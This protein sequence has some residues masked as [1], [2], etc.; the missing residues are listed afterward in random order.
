M[1]KIIVLILS[2]FLITGCGNKMNKQDLQSI[3]DSN[4]YVIIDVRTQEEYNEGHLVNAVNIPYEEVGENVFD[5]NKTI[6]VYCKSGKRSKIAYDTLVKQG[7][8]VYDLGAYESITQF[9]K[10]K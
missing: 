3:I 9:E 4:N 6:L 1:K 8:Q 2:I 5:K 7:Y 10:E